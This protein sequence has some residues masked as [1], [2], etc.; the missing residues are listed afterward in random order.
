[1]D[2]E[3]H[4]EALFMLYL[5]GKSGESYNIGSGINISNIDLIKDFLKIE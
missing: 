1:M 3:D 4:C 5:R 2:T